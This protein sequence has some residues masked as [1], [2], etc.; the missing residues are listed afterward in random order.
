MAR[1]LGGPRKSPFGVFVGLL[2]I[3]IFSALAYR[4]YRQRQNS[5]ALAIHTANGIDEAMQA[6]VLNESL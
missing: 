3:L 5:N 4:A 6:G 1:S 2:V